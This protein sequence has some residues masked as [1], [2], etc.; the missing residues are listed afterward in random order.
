MG[1]YTDLPCFST[2]SVLGE[3]WT[4]VQVV[5]SRLGEKEQAHNNMPVEE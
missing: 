1:L 5:Q 4:V 2:G 3:Y